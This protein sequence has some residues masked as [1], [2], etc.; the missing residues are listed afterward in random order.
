M[1]QM[2]ERKKKS[3]RKRDGLPEASFSRSRKPSGLKSAKTKK[4]LMTSAYVGVVMFYLLYF[5]RPE[6]YIQP[7]NAI[8]MAKISA[9]IA[10]AGLL[11]PVLSKNVKMTTEIGLLLALFAYFC[12]CI[13]TSRWTGGSYEVVINGFSKYVLIILA[14]IWVITSMARLQSII[15]IHILGILSLAL[16]SQQQGMRDGRLF[17]ANAMFGDPN[18]LALHLCIILPLCV[19]LLLSS[20]AWYSKSLLVVAIGF[21]VL[22]ILKT[23]SRGGFLALIAL[24]IA[25]AIKFKVSRR[26]IIIALGLIGVAAIVMVSDATFMERMK[27]ISNPDTDATGSAQIRRELLFRSLQVSAEHPIFGIGPGQFTQMPPFWLQTH[28]TYTQ[29]S[30]EAG[31]A[32]LIIFI[33][34][35]KRSFRNL[36]V[37]REEVPE[38]SLLWYE[39]GAIYCSIVGYLVGAFFLSTVFWLVPYLLVCYCYVLRKLA[40]ESKPKLSHLS[41]KK[42]NPDLGFEPLRLRHPAT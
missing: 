36:R 34:L 28:N 21:I 16:L 4:R 40:E 38:R 12:I 24:S 7:L 35:V 5:F 15:L 29:L 11:G 18:E 42:R 32:S 33:V 37:T 19:A 3:R 2:M 27:T 22:S 13:P 14:S 31:V 20:R 8:P 26:T 6:D 17:G 10:I 41:F 30:A 23:A 1:P 39:S 25:M 9:L